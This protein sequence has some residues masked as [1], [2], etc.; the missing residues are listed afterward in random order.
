MLDADQRLPHARAR[1]VRRHGACDHARPGDAA[2]P[3]RHRQPHGRDQRE[4]RA[5][6]DG[7]VHARRRPRGLHG[8]R[9]ARD[10][11]VAER[12]GRGLD[13]RRPAGRTSASGRGRPLGPERQDRLREVGR[14]S[15]GRTRAA[16][17]SRTRCTRRSSSRSSGATSSRSRRRAGVAAK[18]E[19][20]Y[21]NSGHQ[22]RPVVEAILC[23]PE[24]YEGAAHGQ[25]AGRARRRHAARAERPIDDER[26]VWLMDDAG[27]RLYYPPDV[28]GWDDKRWLDTNTVRAR[29]DDR[30]RGAARQDDHPRDV[31]Q[32]PG[33]D[34][35]RG[36][37]PRRA[38][39]GATRASPARPSPRCA[40]SPR[41]PFP[42]RRARASARSA[43]TRC[44]S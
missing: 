3:R 9:R 13:R 41:P 23:S 15:R 16:S 25:A 19:A 34:R 37:S 14:A 8:D 44:A 38:R 4:L 40:T 5:R 18:L 28:A 24:F 10:G 1:L 35:R 43:R 31:G 39:S 20:L 6:A 12:L 30:Q 22:I 27:Q 21:V 17:S 33:G 29:W 2:L 11:A 26:W 42:P 32:L 7:A 36:R